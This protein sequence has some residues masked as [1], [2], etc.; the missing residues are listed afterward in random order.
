MK[1]DLTLRGM[2]EKEKAYLKK[3]ADLEERSVNNYVIRV[4]RKHMEDHPVRGKK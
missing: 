3:L 2:G 4:L 1:G